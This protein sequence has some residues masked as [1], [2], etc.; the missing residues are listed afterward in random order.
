MTAADHTAPV[1][2]NDR[3][4]TEF[5]V[6]DIIPA[7]ADAGGWSAADRALIDL[8]DDLCRDDCVSDATWAQALAQFGE[9]GVVD[10]IGINGYYSLLSMVMNASRTAVPA[11]KAAPL[12]PLV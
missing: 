2:E 7:P 4:R 10:L 8:A 9:Q 6:T 3:L 11:S 1:V 5:T 12:P